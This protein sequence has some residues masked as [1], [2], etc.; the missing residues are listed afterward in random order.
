M[1]LGTTARL[2][3]RWLNKVAYKYADPQ[4][5]VV[6]MQRSLAKV[7][8]S[9][10]GPWEGDQVDDARN[11]G[12]DLMKALNKGFKLDQWGQ[13]KFKV[14]MGGKKY[15]GLIHWDRGITWLALDGGGVVFY[16]PEHAVQG[17]LKD[18]LYRK[19]PARDRGLVVRRRQRVSK[20]D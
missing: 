5:F 16:E 13:L 18:A 4:E 7:L 1:S 8:Q 10:R 9:G 20:E 3:A 12:M 11:A 15:T 2:A 6:A 19:A 14:A 17:L